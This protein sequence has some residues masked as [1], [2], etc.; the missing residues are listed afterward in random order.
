MLYINIL[1]YYNTA[2]ATTDTVT[3]NQ[4]EKKKFL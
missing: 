1:L 3:H 4:H 2:A